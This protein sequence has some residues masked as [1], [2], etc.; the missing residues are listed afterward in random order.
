M[1]QMSTLTTI[2]DGGIEVTINSMGA[3]MTSLRAGGFEY[4]WGGD[5]AVWSGQAPILFPI[6][7]KL[8]GGAFLHGGRR[9]ELAKHGFIRDS[10]LEVEPI[11]RSSVRFFIEDSAATRAAYPFRFRFEATYAIAA[12]AVRIAFQV[13]NRGEEPMPFSVGAHPAFACNW[14]GTSSISDYRLRFESSGSRSHLL[15]GA[16]GISREHHKLLNGTDL[17][18]LDERTFDRDALI[19]D[20][21]VS[22]VVTLFAE[23]SDRRVRVEFPGF[24]HLGLWSKPGARFVCIEPWF[25][26][27]DFE[28]SSGILLEKEGI[29]VLPPKAT[30]TCEHRIVP[31]S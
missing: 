3:A 24:T 31:S 14:P 25:G 27:D 11:S 29:Q 21:L 10:R 20:G 13:T 5:P 4:L 8:R 23:G 17:L 22:R 28:D 26:L 19:F 7:G 15:M 30:F 18:A 2:E 9:Y 1:E 6:V 12:G 16:E